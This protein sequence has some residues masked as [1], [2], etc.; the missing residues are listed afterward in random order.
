MTEIHP[1][2]RDLDDARLSLTRADQESGQLYNLSLYLI[3]KE[4]T[5]L[6][7]KFSVFSNSEKF[8]QLTDNQYRDTLEALTQNMESARG[9]LGRLRRKT[10]G[11]ILRRNS[12]DFRSELNPARGLSEPPPIVP[13][14]TLSAA[15]SATLPQSTR[16]RLL[17]GDLVFGTEDFVLNSSGPPAYHA[18]EYAGSDLCRDAREHP[19]GFRFTT[20]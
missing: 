17:F 16:E 3:L 6:K 13:P 20:S 5:R 19:P 4:P 12:S 8:V 10:S 11:V 7:K 14:F 1:V 2:I 15:E 18:K 9:V